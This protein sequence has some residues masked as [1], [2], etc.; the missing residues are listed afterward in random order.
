MDTLGAGIRENKKA[1]MREDNRQEMEMIMKETMV[2]GRM[3]E[4]MGD[5]LPHHLP[6]LPWVIMMAKLK[7]KIPGVVK[8]CLACC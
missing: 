8:K 7:D 6:H 5:F 4:M 3:G 1:N 2:L